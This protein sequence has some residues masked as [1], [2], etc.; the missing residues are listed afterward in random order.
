MLRF[1]SHRK[2]KKFY[3]DQRHSI[4]SLIFTHTFD[5][6]NHRSMTS[7]KLLMKIWFI[8]YSYLI[9]NGIPHELRFEVI[10]LHNLIG[11][12]LYYHLN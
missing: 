3:L 2:N 11:F 7:I 1:V 6:I 9:F 5:S 4:N 8:T 10:H 12:F